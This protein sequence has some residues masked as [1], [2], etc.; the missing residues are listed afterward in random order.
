ML[1]VQIKSKENIKPSSPTSPNHPPIQ[2]SSLDHITPQIYTHIL[3]FY[4]STIN[5]NH[6]KT[7]LS[8]TLLHFSPL[9][10]RIHRSSSNGTLYVHCTDEGAVFVEAEAHQAYTIQSFL[11]SDH[12]ASSSSPINEFP[13]LLPIKKDHFNLSDP[14]L[15][16]QLTVFDS[17]GFV[18]G[19]SM[20]HLI[21]D[22]ASMALFLKQWSSISRSGATING[23]LPI[24][25][26][27]S[28]FSPQPWSA[29]TVEKPQDDEQDENTITKVSII[30]RFVIDKE[31]VERLR[32]SKQ[33]WRPTRV[34]AVLGLVW[35]C[36]RRAKLSG[37]H[38]SQVVNIRNKKMNMVSMLS[39]KDFGN[40]WVS[41]M[42]STSSDHQCERIEE[43]EALREAVTSVNEEYVRNFI[44][45]KVKK[46]DACW[47]FTSWCRMGFYE[48]SDFGWGEPDWVGCGLREMKDVC[49][50]IDAKDG[51]GVEVWVWLDE[52]GMKKLECDLEFLSFVSF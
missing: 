34:Q 31:G 2:L 32:I 26:S 10:G 46:S 40:L 18:L 47:I 12:H 27:A 45:G 48:S 28:L 51:V 6:L 50:L 25:D 5:P 16:V 41:V 42:V 14:L 39:E 11:T 9:A 24:F 17:G 30:K 36:L 19:L 21:A 22:G 1:K 49:M 8:T 38:V 35:R 20:C 37:N 3:L 4:S 23:S 43:E 7:S 44:E 15:A 29:S 52:D 13:E 33:S